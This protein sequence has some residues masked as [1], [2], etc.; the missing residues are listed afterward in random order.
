MQK[1]NG[2][3]GVCWWVWHCFW[4]W[5]LIALAPFIFL[6]PLVCQKTK[7]TVPGMIAHGVMNFI[8]IIMITLTVFGLK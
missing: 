6:V 1:L 2:Y 5:Q 4:R 3:D 8:A 7:S